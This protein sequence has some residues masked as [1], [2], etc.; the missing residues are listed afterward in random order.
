MH[1]INNKNH[2]HDKP[3][4]NPPL[5]PMETPEEKQN[6]SHHRYIDPTNHK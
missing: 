2:K 5:K 1:W 6:H 3:K 4:F